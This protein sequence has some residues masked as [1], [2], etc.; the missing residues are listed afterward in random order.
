MAEAL[1]AVSRQANKQIGELDSTIHANHS[2]LF[3][4][5]ITRVKKIRTKKSNREMAFCELEDETGSIE[6]VVFPR[7]YQQ[8][9]ENIVEN[10]VALVKAKVEFQDGEMKLIADKITQPRNLGSNEALNN[11]AHEIFVP[12]KT[13]KQVL[14]DLG[15]LL[16]ANKGKDK[17]VVLIPNGAKPKRMVL[18]YGVK[19]NEKLEVQVKKLLS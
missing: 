7:T 13:D 10:Q 2:F 19:W 4:G 9:A 12:R 3:G 5:I 6:F 15:K 18:P 16:K 14:Q 11:S 17:V 8:Y 1:T